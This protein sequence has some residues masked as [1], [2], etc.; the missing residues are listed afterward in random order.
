[1]LKKNASDRIV[2]R[3][4]FDGG[5]DLL[6]CRALRQLDEP[7]VDADALAASLLH[8]D[9]GG[10]GG[11]VPHK[12]GRQARPSAHPLGEGCGPLG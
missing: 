12:H 10:R 7:R 1:M 2:G 8:F 6:R 5:N 9:V 11:V 3:E 4:L